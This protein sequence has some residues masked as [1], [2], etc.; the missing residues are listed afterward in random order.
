M[1]SSATSY[2]VQNRNCAKKQQINCY[3]ETNVIGGT[4]IGD[5][6]KVKEAQTKTFDSQILDE[7]ILTM[8]EEESNDSFS[9]LLNELVWINNDIEDSLS[10][11]SL[12]M[13]R[14]HYKQLKTFLTKFQ[15]MSGIRTYSKDKLAKKNSIPWDSPKKHTLQLLV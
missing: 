1:A 8:H 4:Y 6:D 9:S 3:L 11:H 5:P 15:S 2:V 14:V 12:S 13:L 7:T 10:N